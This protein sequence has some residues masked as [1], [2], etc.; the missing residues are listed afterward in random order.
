[1]RAFFIY[2]GKRLYRAV[3]TR[4]PIEF[5]CLMRDYSNLEVFDIKEILEENAIL[6]IANR[7]TNVIFEKYGR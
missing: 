1:M 6:A 2:C 5:E 4:D 7:K 3:V